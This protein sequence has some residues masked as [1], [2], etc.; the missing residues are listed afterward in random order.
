M[1]EVTTCKKCGTPLTRAVKYCAQCGTPNAASTARHLSGTGSRSS[2]SRMLEALLWL[3]VVG[4][5]ASIF[6]LEQA[7]RTNS[8]TA[9]GDTGKGLLGLMSWCYLI[10][11]LR[12][13]RNAWMYSFAGFVLTF[14]IICAA[15]ATAAFPR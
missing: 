9:R 8:A 5:S 14:L 7:D 6:F 13:V 1:I 15:V 2:V 12:R 11:K 10:A 4:T 3:A